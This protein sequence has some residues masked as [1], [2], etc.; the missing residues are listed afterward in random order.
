MSGLFLGSQFNWAALAKEA[1]VI[2]IAVKKLSFYLADGTI[3][4]QSDHLPLK[5]F[6]QKTTL[7]A[8]VNNVE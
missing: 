6:L 8:K 3:T 2:Y 1:Y 4:I 5:S 7:N